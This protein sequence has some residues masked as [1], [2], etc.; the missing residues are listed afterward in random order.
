MLVQTLALLDV[1]V[2][3]ELVQKK[4]L[5]AGVACAVIQ[6]LGVVQ[7]IEKEPVVF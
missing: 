3:A 2:L 5:L 1:N 7:V 4:V 6:T